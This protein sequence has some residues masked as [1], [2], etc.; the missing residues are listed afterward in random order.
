MPASPSISRI[1]IPAGSAEGDAEKRGKVACP[2]KNLEGCRGRT[3]RSAP[4]DWIAPGM[5]I[6]S[7]SQSVRVEV[8]DVRGDRTARITP[9]HRC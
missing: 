6:G 4:W 8:P 5:W 1:V 2:L 7:R 3:R 9:P